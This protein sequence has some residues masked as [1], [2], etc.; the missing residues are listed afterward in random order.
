MY[1]TFIMKYIKTDWDIPY[2]NM[3]FEQYLLENG[4]FSGGYFFFYIHRPSVIIGSHQNTYREI[5]YGYIKDCGIIVAR[6]LSGGGA[7]YHDGGNLNFSFVLDRRGND[8][9]D[10]ARYTRPVIKALNDLGCPC[11]LSGRNDLLAG[12]RKF[13]GNAEYR[14]ASKIL[15][16]GTLMFDVDIA[17]M[18]EALSVDSEKFSDKAVDSVRSRV[19]NLKDMLPAGFTVEKLRDAL[20]KEFCR[21]DGGGEYTLTAADTAAVEKLAAEKFSRAEYNFGSRVPFS[22]VKK[23]KFPAGLISAEFNVKNNRIELISIT[24]DYFA[25]GDVR[26]AEDTLS[27]CEYSESAVAA[28][29]ASLGGGKGFDGLISGLNTAEFISLLFS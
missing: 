9:I 21:D 6:R 25:D 28:R 16:H 3:A 20:I 10:F 2:F 26:E 24:G 11:E 19:V 4:K 27:G 12:G 7:V 8:G 18:T 15:H 23:R 5:N 29:L 22:V 14:N 17:A 1:Y 13:S